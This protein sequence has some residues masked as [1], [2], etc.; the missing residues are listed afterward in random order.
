MK[1]MMSNKKRTK[2]VG[3]KKRKGNIIPVTTR[4]I[5]GKHSRGIPRGVMTEGMAQKANIVEMLKAK[6]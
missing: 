2:N 4:L 5:D 1:R 3:V 6:K